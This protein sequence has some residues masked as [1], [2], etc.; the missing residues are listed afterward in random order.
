MKETATDKQSRVLILGGTGMLGH[1]VVRHLF[2]ETPHSVWATA[3]NVSALDAYFY[4]DLVSRFWN[5]NVDADDFDSIARAMTAIQPDV[6][7]NCIGIIKQLPIS[8][9]PLI[10][11]TV[12]SQLPHRIA[13]IS[14]LIGAR[15]IHI[16]TDCV[17]NGKKGMYTEND[18]PTAEDFYGRTKLLGEV[19]YPHC[20]T[21][22]TSIIGHEL[23]SQYGLIEWFLGQSGKVKGYTKAI[24]SGFPTIVMAK[25]ISNYVISNSSLSGLYHVSSEPISKF[26]LLRIVSEKYKKDIE[27]EPF[28]E[29]VVDRSMKSD[30]FRSKTGF[31]PPS[32]DK[33]I[34]AMYRDYKTHRRCYAH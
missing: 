27:I 10:S 33:L 21:L 25:I 22:R 5:H 15:M 20:V 6:V 3:R 31:Q 2:E 34:D 7:I 29:L 8:D 23:R 24:Y 11:I 30:L 32:W 28:E 13:K 9:D 26:D 4:P 1:I 17:F 14:K 16:S 19:T 18:I 12:N